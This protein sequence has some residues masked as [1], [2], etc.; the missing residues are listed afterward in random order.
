GMIDFMNEVGLLKAEFQVEYLNA[1][2]AALA[3]AT[4][5]IKGVASVGASGDA[6]WT[7]EIPEAKADDFDVVRPIFMA[8]VA[9][10]DGDAF[11]QKAQGLEECILESSNKVMKAASVARATAKALRAWGAHQKDQNGAE[12][13]RELRKALKAVT[14][15]PSLGNSSC[16][17]QAAVRKWAFDAAQ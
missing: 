15:H 9:E 12:L 14:D 4:D 1:A 7:G 11:S 6:S 2:L 3:A 10:L 5:S 13:R 8:A 16:E 17:M